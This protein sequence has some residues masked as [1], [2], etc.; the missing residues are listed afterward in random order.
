MRLKLALLL[1]LASPSAHAAAICPSLPYSFTN[2]S[3]A[4]ATQ[5]N[6]NFS[7]IQNCVN[8]GAANAGANTN[9]TS[10]PTLATINVT[11]IGSLGQISVAGTGV[12]GG[13]LT[14][15]GIG[16]WQVPTGTT[17]QRSGSPANGMVRYNTTLNTY[18]GVVSANG[19]TVWQAISGLTVVAPGGRLTLTTGTPVLSGAVLAATT[20]Y[21]T[22]HAN[23]VVPLWNGASFNLQ[24]CAEL[25][26]VL[27]ASSSGN[28]GPAAAVAGSVYDLFVWSNAG[29]CTLTRGPAWATLT[30][31]SMTLA[32]QNGMLVNATAITN[33]PA[34]GY[35]TYV[36]TVV[37]DAGGATVTFNPTPAAAS[38]GPTNGAWVGLWN[39]YNRVFLAASAKDNNS[40]WAYT[41]SAWRAADASNNN[42][43]SFVTG[44]AEDAL[45]AQYTAYNYGGS[46]GAGV[47]VDS[48]T[49]PGVIGF[50]GN[51]TAG[52]ISTPPY[53]SIGLVGVHYIQ[54]LEYAY[55]TTSFYPS[56]STAI[57]G[58]PAGQAQA[59][60]ATLRY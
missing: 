5:V 32:R 9:I 19:A 39:T 3:V 35:G 8:T 14:S 25:S 12:F 43:V 31:R 51:L 44:L 27:S 4:D 18:E 10:L 56:P 20:V 48:T 45:S 55:G 6:A 15:T 28:A 50:N 46:A 22:P 21:Y 1:L 23:D 58:F 11:G 2:G 54:A 36:G 38:G 57:A 24:D 53:A 26:N 49:T 30:T 33:G 59:L 52:Q 47:A 7:A 16:E 34:G 60:T 13:D 17:A 37:T 40:F 42:R 29:V 41:V